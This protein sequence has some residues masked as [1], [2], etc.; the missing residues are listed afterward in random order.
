MKHIR[1]K[2]AEIDDM[3]GT[4]AGVLDNLSDLSMQMKEE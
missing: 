1:K 3:L 4:M 2:D